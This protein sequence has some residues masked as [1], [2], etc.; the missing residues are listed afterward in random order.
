[1]DVTLR[2]VESGF[3]CLRAFRPRRVSGKQL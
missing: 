3:P 2:G 1:L